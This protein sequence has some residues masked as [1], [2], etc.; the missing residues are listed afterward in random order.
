MRCLWSSADETVSYVVKW[1]KWSKLA[2]STKSKSMKF[3]KP[4]KVTK[5]KRNLHYIGITIE[6]YRLLYTS[7]V[8]R[9]RSKIIFSSFVTLSVKKL[10]HYRE[11]GLL[12]YRA[13]LLHYRA[14]RWAIITSSVVTYSTEW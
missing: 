11:G 9:Y 2:K 4:P 14:R 10:L 5:S 3:E 6:V 7:M 1:A 13:F 8:L 12:H